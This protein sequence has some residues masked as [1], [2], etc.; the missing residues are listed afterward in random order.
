MGTYLLSDIHG[1]ADA[2][3]GMLKTIDFSS[4]DLL[5]VL[6]DVIDRG[7]N[8]I[9][10]LRQILRM[11]NC[12]L[13]LGNH[14]YMMIEALRTKC[15]DKEIL[16]WERN[17]CEPTFRAFQ[18][19][20]HGEQENLLDDLQQL[21]VDLNIRAGGREYFLVHG[22]PG[23]NTHDC[24]WGRPENLSQEEPVPGRQLIVGH[25]PVPLVLCRTEEERQLYYRKMEKTGAL[26]RILHAPGFWDLDCGCGHTAPGGALGCIRLED[27]R[28]FYVPGRR[29]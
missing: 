1:M 12:V 13:L 6:G 16:R 21:P 27:L 17:G 23:E 25:T 24:V 10:L 19:L 11:D 9:A 20:S 7:E 28:E 22:F 26:N 18:Q 15:T 4:S 14:E 5:Y 29:S 2:F 3:E 8:G